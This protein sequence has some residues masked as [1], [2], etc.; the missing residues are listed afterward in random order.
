MVEIDA[1]A[2]VRQDDATPIRLTGVDAETVTLVAGVRWRGDRF[3]S[4]TTFAVSDGVVDTAADAPTEGPY[5]G[6]EPTGW[7][8]AATPAAD[9]AV[10]TADGDIAAGEAPVR[11][12]ARID[13]KRRATAE[14]RRSVTDP[15]VERR[16]VE[17]E[18][19]A[20]E[21]FLAAGDGPHPGVVALHG[22]GGRPPL[23]VAGL[24]AAEGYAAFALRWLDHPTTPT[25]SLT[26]VP[27]SHVDRAAAFLREQ[28]AVRDE[29]GVWGISKGGE[30]ALQVGARR[31]WPA[32][33]VAAS[34]SAIA[35]PGQEPGRSSWADDGE[36]VSFL[37]P[38]ADPPEDAPSAPR[39][40]IA[41]MLDAA[42]DD[43]LARRTPPLDEGSPPTL[44]LSGECDAVW[45]AARLCRPAVERLDTAGVRVEHRL[46]SDAGHTLL[47]P[48]HP[49][50]PRTG[51]TGRGNRRGA[52]EGWRATRSFLGAELGP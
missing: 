16:W 12:E 27:L 49:T 19:V 15:A 34:G 22:S 25:D 37:S 1:T 52:V 6:V 7:L 2:T 24:L 20:G 50:T 44:L 23:G 47:P 39:H 42:S 13:G 29:V 40:R 11:F 28:P 32:A 41:L 35:M 36:P 4:R 33:V 38:P 46:F 18:A 14:Q 10:D 21:L 30:L 48:Q 9:K 8:W 26:E 5:D 51:G 31:D 43:E 3:V 17:T 45:P